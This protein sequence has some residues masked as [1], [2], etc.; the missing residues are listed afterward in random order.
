[1][2]PVTIKSV[3][4]LFSSIELVPND[5]EPYIYRGEPT[6]FDPPCTPSLFRAIQTPM[7]MDFHGGFDE[8][9]MMVK[10]FSAYIVA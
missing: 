3:S 9:K 1:M 4:D 7:S 6:L 2:Y 5:S 8:Q 10:F